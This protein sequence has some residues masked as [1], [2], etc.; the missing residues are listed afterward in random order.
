MYYVTYQY[1]SFSEAG[2]LSADR[3][4]VVPVTTIG[5]V[6]GIKLP[7]RMIDFISAADDE[8]IANIERAMAQNP[9][10]GIDLARVRLL[11]PIPKPA[12]NIFCLGKNYADHVGEIKNIAGLEGAPKAPIYF[13]KLPSTVTGPDS[14]ILSH[15]NLTKQVDYEAEL[16]VIIGTEG[17]EIPVEKAED[18][19]FGYTV[20]NDITARDIQRM[21][22]QWYKG[23]SLDTFC[24]MGP[25]IVHK[26]A[27]PLPISAGIRC[28]I[29]GE[30]R[31]ESNI[32]HML[33]DIPFIINDL[34]QG[35]TLYP[36]DIILT[37]TPAGVGIAQDPPRFLKHGDVLE[38]EV[39]GIGTLRNTIK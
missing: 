26:N 21:H 18:Y 17:T 10:M 14:P 28:R 8:L 5:K 9:N 33:F 3:K 16:A 7:E 20:A 37:G 25:A 27:M 1:A 31:Q 29:N 30:L 32:D 6:M 4:R 39:D 15:A 2:I 34:S 13:S 11:A 35:V 19:I 38:T 36:G 24:P 22:S 23:K 12:R